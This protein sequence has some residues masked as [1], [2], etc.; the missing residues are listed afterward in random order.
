MTRRAGSWASLSVCFR[1]DHAIDEPI[2]R[3]I[4]AAGLTL[5][6]PLRVSATVGSLGP[7]PPERTRRPPVAS[8]RGRVL[9]GLG[10]GGEPMTPTDQDLTGHRCLA[11]HFTAAYPRPT[12]PASVA[13]HGATGPPA[14]TL[15]WG[16]REPLR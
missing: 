14:S 3:A 10:K 1:Q 12:I 13:R 16:R 8:L 15:R 9:L 2:D 4:P 7:I 5:T 11:G 6:P